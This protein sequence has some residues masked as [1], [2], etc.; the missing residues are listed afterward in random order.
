MNEID[1]DFQNLKIWETIAEYFN[2]EIIFEDKS[3]IRK[4]SN[5]YAMF[6]HGIL[7]IAH[8]F[9]STNACNFSQNIPLPERKR[10]AIL[11]TLFAI[12]ILGKACLQLGGINASRDTLSIALDD[13]YSFTLY[14]GGVH[15]MMLSRRGEHILYLKKRSGFIKL[16]LE[17]DADIIPIYVF[18]ETSLFNVLHLP[19]IENIQSYIETTFMIGLPLFWSDGFI[20]FIP[21]RVPINIVVGKPIYVAKLIDEHFAGIDT[22][23]ETKVDYIHAYFQTE[24]T[25]LFDEN[26]SKY[27]CGSAELKI[28]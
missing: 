3:L 2:V 20:P 19:F 17:H 14:P 18:G 25:R 1:F 23:M 26:K 7:S 4:K 21:N 9:L 10:S 28:M 27:G 16:A 13:N 15:E 22:P 11:D 12:P 6:P 24:I 8:L 5:I